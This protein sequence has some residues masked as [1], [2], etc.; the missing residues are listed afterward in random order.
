MNLMRMREYIKK[1]R[2]SMKDHEMLIERIISEIISVQ[3]LYN[4][5]FEK[6]DYQAIQ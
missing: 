1:G 6:T 3:M 4:I 5:K 2:L